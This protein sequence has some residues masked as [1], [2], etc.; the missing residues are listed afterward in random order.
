MKQLSTALHDATPGHESGDLALIGRALVHADRVGT[1]TARRIVEVLG[2]NP[3]LPTARELLGEALNG[4]AR[5]DQ[6]L[7]QTTDSCRT[8]LT[9]EEIDVLNEN[10]QVVSQEQER[11]QSLA[12]QSG[13]DTEKWAPVANRLRV[14]LAELRGLEDL[15]GG[16]ADH[17]T[18]A[19]ADRMRNLQKLLNKAPHDAGSCAG[20]EARR[21]IAR[22]D[23][24]AFASA[25][26][27]DAPGARHGPGFA[28]ADGGY[29]A[30]PGA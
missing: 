3:A 6:I 24:G 15:S 28:T 4:I 30:V 2:N 29:A 26:R 17:G 8:T 9:A 1:E 5:T 13:T 10:L 12:H 11:L 21:G 14:V 16:T 23:D 25:V 7:R 20:R 19:M 27:W 18:R 22:A